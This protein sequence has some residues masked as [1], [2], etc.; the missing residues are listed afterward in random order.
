MTMLGEN[1]MEASEYRELGVDDE[2][3]VDASLHMHDPISGRQQA[4]R[5]G[6][7]KGFIEPARNHAEVGV[8]G[9]EGGSLNLGKTDPCRS[10]VLGSRLG[11]GGYHEEQQQRMGEIDLEI[12]TSFDLERDKAASERQ[13]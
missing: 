11:S 2:E 8:L 5:S 6:K 3:V 12:D 10:G 7:E 13:L 9:R 4:I 1:D